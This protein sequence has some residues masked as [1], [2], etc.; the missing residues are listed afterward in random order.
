MDTC[1]S[2]PG[3]KLR[4]PFG[5]G[6]PARHGML[7]GSNEQERSSGG[8]EGGAGAQERENCRA[9]IDFLFYSQIKKREEKARVE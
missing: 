9:A 6:R 7:W 3:S 4:H 1:A 5:G 2:S 8:G